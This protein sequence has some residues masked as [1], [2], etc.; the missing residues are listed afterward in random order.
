[1]TK[2]LNTYDV[3]SAAAPIRLPALGRNPPK[4]AFI[5]L[6]RVHPRSISP[7]KGPAGL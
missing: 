3:L 4:S 2:A 6:I 7:V 5:R 1:M